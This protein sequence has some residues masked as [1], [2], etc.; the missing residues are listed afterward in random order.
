[1]QNVPPAD[2][3][4]NHSYGAGVG[5]GSTEDLAL[6]AAYAS[7]VEDADK[8]Q[9]IRPP[10]NLARRRRCE[11][12]VPLAEGYKAFVLVKAQKSALVRNDV[13]DPD[14][15]T[16]TTPGFEERLAAYH[17]KVQSSRYLDQA[18][19]FEP[20]GEAAQILADYLETAVLALAPQAKFARA[21]EDA[22]Q[23]VRLEVES[24]NCNAV[25]ICTA[26]AKAS[27]SRNMLAA[28]AK[29]GAPPTPAMR[30]YSNA[31]ISG[32][33]RPVASSIS[34]MDMPL[35]SIHCA[36]FCAWR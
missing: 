21:K 32:S 19:F 15:V 26:A 27:V 23:L 34:A 10:Y 6:K 18:V 24:M 8:G 14:T 35:E 2:P 17:K 4:K 3:T 1:M 9:G 29:E 30:G 5:T 22:Q 28:R 12:V 7:A 20:Q 13:N 25:V 31:R 36:I 11:E 33:S 16:C